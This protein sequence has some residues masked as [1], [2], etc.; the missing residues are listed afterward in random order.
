MTGVLIDNACGAKQKDEAAAAKHP[1]ACSKKDSC[2]ASGYQL[3]V[4]DKHYKLSD[5]G[6]DEAKAY[7]E[8]A[9]STHV[10][11][12][13]KL[14]GDIIQCPWHGS[15]FSIRDG[16]VVDGPAVHPQPCLETRI[17]NGQIEVR[18]YHSQVLTTN[19]IQA[20]K[21]PVSRTGTMG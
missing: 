2:A 20:G 14:D 16:H 1:M 18:K 3:V 17:H 7:L 13:G 15:R 8:K 21:K 11:V 19:P 4:G 10:T 12:E 5:K 9:T 6:N